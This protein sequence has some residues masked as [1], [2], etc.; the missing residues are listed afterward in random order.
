MRFPDGPRVIYEKNPLV[1]VVCQIRFDPILRIQTE[2]PA[3]F[4]DRIRRDYPGYAE[5]RSVAVD[6]PAEIPDQVRNAFESLFGP[7][8]ETVNY[9][10]KSR[11][12]STR[13]TLARDFVAL[14]TTKYE[15]WEIFRE[16]MDHIVTQVR[17]VYQ[18]SGFKRIGLRYKDVIVRSQ[19]GLPDSP[20]S[21]LLRQEIAGELANPEW[22]PQIVGLLKQIRFSGDSNGIELTLNHGI[23]NVEHDGSDQEELGYLID[24]DFS[25][26][27]TTDDDD[28]LAILDRANR[29][30]GRLFQWCISERLHTA[31]RPRDPSD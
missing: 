23:V 14:T 7:A 16:Q 3:E 29:D 9:E 4:Q 30:A 12:E 18:P 20:W 8:A 26:E 28:A 15:R 11:D 17:D 6:M 24:G 22:E 5:T 10:F 21:E 2:P 13:V 19:L 25:R 1:E 27:G 31:L